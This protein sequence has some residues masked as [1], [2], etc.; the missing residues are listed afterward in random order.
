MKQL[1]I[2]ILLFL[3][4]ILTFAAEIQIPLQ[5]DWQFRQVGKTEWMNAQVPG[6]VHTDLLANG[7]IEDPFF[8]M[9]EKDLQWIEREDWE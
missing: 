4:P 7:L 5:T 3:F 9:N 2:F 6:T 1:N 8:R